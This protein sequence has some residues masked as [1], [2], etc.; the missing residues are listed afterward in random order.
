MD[1]WDFAGAKIAERKFCGQYIGRHVR[2]IG[3]LILLAVLVG[4]GSSA[5]RARLQRRT[6]EAQ[7]ALR[8]ERGRCAAARTDMAAA[9]KLRLRMEWQRSLGDVTGQSVRLLSMISTTAPE[10]VWLSRVQNPD[11]KPVISVAGLAQDYASLS[12]FLST[13]RA[14]PSVT[15]VRLTDA[16]T[17][18]DKT[19]RVT[20]AADMLL[21]S[22]EASATP[23][24]ASGHAAGADT[25]RP[26]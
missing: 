5:A 25:Q 4:A 8:Q 20:F 24:T 12:L 16:R 26:F 9:E 19:K 23:Q 6:S 17:A 3:L 11:G 1:H 22:A 21:V 14:S 15:D 13:L 7:L 10:G 2:V 18:D